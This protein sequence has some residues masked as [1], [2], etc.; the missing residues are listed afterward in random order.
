MC[1]LW[2]ECVEMEVCS[3]WFNSLFAWKP[4]STWHRTQQ[5]VVITSCTLYVSCVLGPLGRIHNKTSPRINSNLGIHVDKCYSKVQGGFLRD[6]HGPA[7]GICFTRYRSPSSRKQTRK[8]RVDSLTWVKHT[9]QCLGVILSGHA[10]PS[11]SPALWAGSSS[12]QRSHPHRGSPPLF[13]RYVH[14][15]KSRA[16]T[17]GR[18]S[19]CWGASGGKPH[20]SN[21]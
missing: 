16:S 20:L 1:L 4:G 12:P 2:Q 21:G 8:W 5:T 7:G 9:R 6:P 19:T 17:S 3:I 14:M 18:A 10:C 11:P 15:W 13:G